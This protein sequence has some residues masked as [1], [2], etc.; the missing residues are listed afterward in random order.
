[1][2]RR[3]EAQHEQ[4]EPP[5]LHGAVADEPT[6]RRHSHVSGGQ[7]AF[8][9][10]IAAATIVVIRILGDWWS[11]GFSITFPDSSSYL[12]VARIGPLWPSFWF[13]ERPV[14]FPLFI[15]IFGHS[16]RLT[17]FAQTLVYVAAFSALIVA[18]WRSLQ[19]RVARVVA[20]YSSPPSPP[21]PDSPCGTH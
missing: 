16:E 1:M 17:V 12:K 3:G 20:P 15:W 11:G 8:H 10:G 14:G 19:S 5:E 13:D 7:I 9:G 4:P 2:P 6:R 21:S 18:V